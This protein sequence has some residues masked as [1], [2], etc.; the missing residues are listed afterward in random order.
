M[1]NIFFIWLLCTLISKNAF[2]QTSNELA[3]NYLSFKVGSIVKCVDGSI[4]FN[5]TFLKE[6]SSPYDL[7]MIGVIRDSLD[8]T[9]PRIFMSPIIKEGI[10]LVRYN[11]TNGVI[12]RG[13]P[14][15]SSF[16][17]GEA[18]KATQPGM[19]LGVAMEDGDGSTPFLKVRVMIQYFT[20]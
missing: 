15:T 9:N 18:M 3:N 5:Y 1:K 20:P 17:S 19:I 7:E 14:I 8:Y 10:A 6:V 13:D 16:I 11:I 12:K 2:S 4:P